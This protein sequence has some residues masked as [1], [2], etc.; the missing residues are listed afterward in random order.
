L[1][2]TNPVTDFI[3]YTPVQ[4]TQTATNGL[5]KD[6][7]MKL[8][9]AQMRQQ[10]PMEPTDD[11]EMIAQMTQF[12]MLEQLQSLASSGEQSATAGHVSQAVSLIG[13]DV[14]YVG[15]DGATGSGTVSS[16]NFV[17]GAPQLTIGGV[18][19]ITPSQV[20]QVR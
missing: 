18:N 20:T 12:S 14:T 1:P 4:K 7:F 6:T 15:S 11:K 13:H 3:G 16:V 5:G 2:S 19:G 8:L 9:V 10:N 17:D